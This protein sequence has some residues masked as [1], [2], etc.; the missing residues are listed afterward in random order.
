VTVIVV[1]CTGIATAQSS[2]T[3]IANVVARLIEAF[4]HFVLAKRRKESTS[5]LIALPC[6]F[7]D[8]GRI[9]WPNHSAFGKRNW[10]VPKRDSISP[11]SVSSPDESLKQR[12][13]EDA[14][15]G[16]IGLWERSKN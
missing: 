7:Q 8:H 3:Q 1:A 16:L 6:A 14:F 12:S 13:P 15:C 4:Y 5:G 2:N 9:V 11:I 10:T